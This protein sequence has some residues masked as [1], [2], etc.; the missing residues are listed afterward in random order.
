[1]GF[2]NVISILDRDVLFIEFLALKIHRNY[3][4]ELCGISKD[5]M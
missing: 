1:M 2:L 5:C 4:G 3:V